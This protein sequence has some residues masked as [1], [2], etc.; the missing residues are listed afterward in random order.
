MPSFFRLEF[1]FC[2]ICKRDAD[3]R[4]TQITKQTVVDNMG[5]SIHLSSRCHSCHGRLQRCSTMFIPK[6]LPSREQ[7]LSDSEC[8]MDKN[9]VSDYDV[10][11]G[12]D[13]T[14]TRPVVRSDRLKGVSSDSKRCRADQQRE[15]VRKV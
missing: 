10:L 12:K 2:P 1:T 13:C 15:R 14:S 9:F 5:R 11:K 6:D 8:F 3:H 4:I 7:E